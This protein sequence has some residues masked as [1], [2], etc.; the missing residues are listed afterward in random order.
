MCA[1]LTRLGKPGLI[2][3]NQRHG[4]E[5]IANM[6][7]DRRLPLS[8]LAPVL[9]SGHVARFP[10]Q[11]KV[12][13][14]NDEG[15]ARMSDEGCPNESPSVDDATGYAEEEEVDSIGCEEVL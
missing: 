10:D 6:I 4:F 13:N 9:T 15:S 14:P 11:P 7:S 12:L 8:S 3:F 5:R 1:L 2:R